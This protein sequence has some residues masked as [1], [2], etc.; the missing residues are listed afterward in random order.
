MSPGEEARQA[1]YDD[2]NSVDP[3]KEGISMQ[4]MIKWGE[5]LFVKFAGMRQAAAQ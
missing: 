2:L 1:H 5:V 3:D 4:E